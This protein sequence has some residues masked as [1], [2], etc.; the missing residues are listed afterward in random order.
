MDNGAE[1]K[2]VRVTIFHQ[3]YTVES[4]EPEQIEALAHEIDELMVSI[5]RQ[6]SNADST[7]VAVLACLHLADRLR[8]TDREFSGLKSR[9]SEKARQFSLLLD[10]AASQRGA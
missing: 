10:E 5:A 9:V 2:N 3:Q 1:R 4:D 6:V 8:E 7:R